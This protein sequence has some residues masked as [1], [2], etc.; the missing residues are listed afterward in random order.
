MKKFLV[1]FVLAFSL[2]SFTSSKYVG[3]SSN[4]DVTEKSEALNSYE[5]SI[6]YSDEIECWTCTLTVVFP[7]FTTT[8]IIG[9]SCVSPG[10]AC[11]YARQEL[12][13]RLE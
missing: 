9:E 10:M 6:D 13:R 1:L 2:M 5:I 12:S 8:T 7:D 3:I 11:L 4:N